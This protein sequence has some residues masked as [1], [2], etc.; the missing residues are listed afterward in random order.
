MPKKHKLYEKKFRVLVLFRK[1]GK[2]INNKI[3]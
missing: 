3:I 1:R 2:K